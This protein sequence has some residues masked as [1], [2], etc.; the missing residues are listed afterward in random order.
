MQYRAHQLTGKTGELSKL[1]EAVN[2]SFYAC[3]KHI[4]ERG[5]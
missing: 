2:R 4:I 5:P 3:V 1:E